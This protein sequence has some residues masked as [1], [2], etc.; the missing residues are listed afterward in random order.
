M[1]KLLVIAALALMSTSVNAEVRD[2]TF[3]GHTVRID[4]PRH[5][6]SISCI[7]LFEVPRSGR[8]SARGRHRSIAAMGGA[9]AAN[10][11]AAAAPVTQGTARVAS[12]LP[13][14][15]SASAPEPVPF[16]RAE[17]QSV[18]QP[19][20]RSP[21]ALLPTGSAVEESKAAAAYAAPVDRP[22]ADQSAAQPGQADPPSP[23]G[24]W[25]TQKRESRVR[26]ELCGQALCGFVDGKPDKKV[27]INMQPQGNRW[28]GKINDLRS[29]GT[30]M[31]NISLKGA[32]SLRVEGCAF[33]GLFC[34][35]ETWTRVE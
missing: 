35:G 23:V 24:V 14:S 30:Y 11:A 32:S 33:G 18:P 9:P 17:P 7:R 2:I 1:R 28:S 16:A 8:R 20:E 29:G 4:L 15:G 19:E 5:C 13:T 34:G 3:G 26:I 27:L 12:G 10:G 6:M 25:L 21:V 22:N 31:A